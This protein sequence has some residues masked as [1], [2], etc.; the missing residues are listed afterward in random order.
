[1]L[2]SL[3]HH[4]GYLE[5]DHRDSPGLT[6]ADVA[7]IP[8]A[9]PVA[10]GSVLERDVKQCSHC[11]RTIVLQPLRVRDRGYCPKCD[12]YV[13]DD[14]ETIRVKTGACVPAVQMFDAVQ[15]RLAT[16]V[17]RG[18]PVPS[19]PTILLTDKE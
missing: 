7:H 19:D 4:A 17:D 13:C 11:Q 9:M 12:H 1:M 5:I 8:G 6:A 14:C 18:E 15:N 16:R 2:K 10:A 3:R